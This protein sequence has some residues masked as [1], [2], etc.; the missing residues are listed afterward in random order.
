MSLGVSDY[1]GIA[2]FGGE[3]S[4]RELLLPVAL[5][6]AF[7]IAALGAMLPIRR[8][9]MVKPAIVLKEAR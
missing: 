2:V 3:L 8:A 5:M 1:I 4:Q 9:L 6:S 7:G